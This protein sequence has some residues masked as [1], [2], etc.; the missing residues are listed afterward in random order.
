MENIN[1]INQVQKSEEEI[2]KEKIQKLEKL[3]MGPAPKAEI[4]L[5]LLGE[6]LAAE[7]LIFP[8]SDKEKIKKSLEEL[9]LIVK[10]KESRKFS[11]A[12]SAIAIAKDEATAERLVNADPSKDHEEFG[13]LMSYPGTAIEAFGKK[14]LQFNEEDENY[15]DFKDII[16]KFQLSKKNWQEEFELLKKWSKSIKKYSPETFNDLNGLYS[17]EKEKNK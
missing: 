8:N 3:E 14:K 17:L 12:E 16:F 10:E 4:M 7:L 11:K 9:G 6:K 5:V 2:N 1:Q 15:P 13:E